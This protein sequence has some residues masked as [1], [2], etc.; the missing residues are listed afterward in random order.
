VLSHIPV[1]DC[2]QKVVLILPQD[3]CSIGTALHD[4]TK[5]A[6]CGLVLHA[7]RSMLKREVHWQW[8]RLIAGDWVP[9]R[10]ARRAPHTLVKSMAIP[11]SNCKKVVLTS[12]T[13][14]FVLIGTALHQY[15]TRPALR[16]GS[17]RQQRHVA[18]RGGRGSNTLNLRVTGYPSSTAFGRACIHC[19]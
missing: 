17:S 4:S 18:G 13:G 8:S 2:G 12:T 7:A 14:P 10:Q 11:V 16:F 6:H 15:K 5:S 9:F 19:C 1:S 3:L